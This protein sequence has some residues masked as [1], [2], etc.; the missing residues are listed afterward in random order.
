MRLPGLILIV[1][2]T[3]VPVIWFAPLAGERDAVALF[4]QYLGASA[5]ILMGINQFLA[6]RVAG[7][8]TIFGSLD[9]IYILHKWLGVVALVAMG[10]H[11]IIDAEMNGLRGG[12]LS[13]IAEDIGEVSLY[14]LLILILAS[15]IT[16][17]PYH[18]WKWS[19]RLIGV[20]FLMGA[21]HYFF[22]EKPF[23]NFE[24][25]GL[26]ISAFCILGIVSYVWMSLLRPMTPRGH[27]YEVDL[28]RR[29]GGLTELVLL[30]KGR[31]MKHKPGQFA[32]LSINDG[33][34]GEEHPF[35]LSGA[36]AQ[37]RSLRFSIKDLGDY[38]KRLHKTV[39][40]GMEAL[41]CGPYGHF[42]MPKGRDPQ[43]W[44]GAGVGI[45]PFLAFAESLRTAD[46]GPVKLYY[47]VREQ[48]DVPY[49][50]ELENIA[51]AV[52]N[53]ELVIVNSAEGIRLTADRIA[54]DLDGDLSTAHVF[55]CGPV[56]MRKALKTDLVLK[57]MRASRFHFEEFEMRTGIG[58]RV[59]AAWLWDRGVYELEKRNSALRQPAE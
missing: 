44:I 18:L 5:L 29:V 27:V 38:T 26:Y 59:L 22:I 7:I 16:F 2:A 47:C 42:S 48:D 56:A 30:P 58:L 40:P 57:G 3:L 54:G 46:A 25:L 23:S 55:F 6:T 50:V 33:A 4:S 1:L 41:V 28:V 34:L 31:G 17:I 13:G 35:T 45:T 37:D 49:A 21:F 19:H 43:I 10:L 39:E 9:R 20:F 15:V 52:P 14:G 11:D 24:P 36:P 8:E 51:E 32:F 53:L 12:P